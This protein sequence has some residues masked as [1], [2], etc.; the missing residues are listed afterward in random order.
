MGWASALLRI[1]LQ[2]KACSREAVEK[3][4]RTMLAKVIVRGGAAGGLENAI[5]ACGD[6]LGDTRLPTPNATVLTQATYE[7]LKADGW[8]AL[9]R[10]SQ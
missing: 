10:P 9:G 1:L 7:C 4:H 8:Y 2:R 6:K 5:A 3:S